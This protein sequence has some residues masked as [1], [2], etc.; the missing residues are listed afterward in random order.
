MAIQPAP[1]FAVKARARGPEAAIQSGIGS[2]VL[3]SPSFGFSKRI[4]RRFFS[5][6]AS[7]VSP[8]NN[9]MTTRT[10]S[11][12]SASLTAP[13]PIA[14]LPVKPV[15]TPKSI[16][17]GANLFNEAKAFA[18]AGGMRFDGISTPVP[19]RILVVFNAAAAIATNGSALS[20]W[21]S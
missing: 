15:P 21:V 13:S 19:S 16:R 18:V 10:Y 11:S 4:N 5:I 2:R 3:I 14:R 7:T 6:S 20:I 8:R 1:S 17:P 12:M 9:A